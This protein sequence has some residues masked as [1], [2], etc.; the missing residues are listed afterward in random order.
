M[1]ADG[2]VNS[3][4]SPV[5]SLNWTGKPLSLITAPHMVPSWS[6]YYW[7]NGDVWHYGSHMLGD[8]TGLRAPGNQL[9]SKAVCTC[10]EGS[11]RGCHGPTSELWPFH[12]LIYWYNVQALQEKQRRRS[13]ETNAEMAQRQRRNQG[14]R[15]IKAFGHSDIFIL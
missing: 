6:G 11:G 10:M 14:L 5:Q 8:Q 2:D 9:R 13:T 15:K 4:C 1:A 7:G 12:S 3:Y